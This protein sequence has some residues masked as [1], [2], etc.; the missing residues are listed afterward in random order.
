MTARV[1]RAFSAD[2]DL[3]SAAQLVAGNTPAGIEE[4]RQA[5][6]DAMTAGG[7]A[8]DYWHNRITTEAASIRSTESRA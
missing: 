2:F 1:P 8:A 7:D 5:I 4:I 3:W 6:R